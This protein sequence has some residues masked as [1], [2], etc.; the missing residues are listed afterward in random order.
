MQRDR[1]AEG[2]SLLLGAFR[3]DVAAVFPCD[4][5]RNRKPQSEAAGI[6]GP[7]FVGSVEAVEDVGQ[8]FGG[9]G[10]AFVMHGKRRVF[11]TFGKLHGY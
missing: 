7:G 6:A 1:C 3:A 4:F 5:A 2:G 9:D 10:L 11:C 8:V